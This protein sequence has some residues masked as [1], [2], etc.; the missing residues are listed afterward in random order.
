M[1]DVAELAA[2]FVRA[3]MEM[4]RGVRCQRHDGKHHHD[5]KQPAEYLSFSPRL[6]LHPV[7][8]PGQPQPMKTARRTVP[9]KRS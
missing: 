2:G 3:I 8:H 1:A 6:Y 7:L 9:E 5:G 4:R